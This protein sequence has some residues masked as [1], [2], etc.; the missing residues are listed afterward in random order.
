MANSWRIHG[1]FMANSM[2]GRTN[3][4]N[5]NGS[6]E[7]LLDLETRTTKDDHQSLRLWLRLLS[8]SVRIENHVRARLRQ[9]FD[10]TLPRFD[11]MAQ[12]ERSPEGLR[13]TE[14]S[15]RMMVSGGNITGITDQLE[16]EGLVLRI[17][18]HNDR[19]ALTVK[20]T[21][22]GKMRF[23]EMATHHEEWV[24]QLFRGLNREEKQ[25]LFSLLQK[26]KSHLRV[27]IPNG[28]AATLDAS[29][30]TK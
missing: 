9:E 24:T 28:A 17:S 18:D 11:L 22:K 19:R 5:G 29:Q 7:I 6:G 2:T 14:L 12:L 1:K 4:S 10:T 30:R 16:G 15:K 21:E 26:M 23:R 25:E 27:L 8:C 20:L 13:M 3:A